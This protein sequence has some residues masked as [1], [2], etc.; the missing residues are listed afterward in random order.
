M[1]EQGINS[2]AA[3]ASG[4]K[5]QNLITDFP[6]FGVQTSGQMD[7]SNFHVKYLKLDVDDPVALNELESLETKG[8]LGTTTIILKKESW[9]F[10]D[11]FFMLVTY[12]EKNETA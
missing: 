7:M 11:K 4:I 6:G 2:A 5:T 9:T 8:L 1:A 12:L 10:M 3:L